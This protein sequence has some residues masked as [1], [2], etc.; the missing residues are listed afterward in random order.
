VIEPDGLQNDVERI[1]GSWW[2]VLLLG[3]LGVAAGV[4]LIVEPSI[5]LATLAWVSG[6]FLLVDGVFELIG[7]VSRGVEQRGLLAL[8]G[9][10]S[11]I[12]GLFLVRHPIAAVVAIA[13]LLGIWLV[14]FG[15]VRFV[16]AFGHA[17]RHRLLSLL[18]AGVEVVAGVVI[19]A[20]PSIGIGTLAIVAGIAF[21]LRGIG[22]TMLALALRAAQRL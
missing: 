18:L 1:T 15:V 11:I 10:L 16:E 19:V 4:V 9:V 2:L 5:S 6:V 17:G 21:V 3:L 12:T 13:L 7:A 8:L 14:T 20:A 22:T